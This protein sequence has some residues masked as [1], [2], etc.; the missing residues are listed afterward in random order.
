MK[1]NI[2]EIIKQLEEIANNLYEYDEKRGTQDNRE[3]H[4]FINS[5]LESLDE[6]LLCEMKV[7][8]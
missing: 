2:K 1:E 8:K 5:A 4:E 7:K 3:A 6:S